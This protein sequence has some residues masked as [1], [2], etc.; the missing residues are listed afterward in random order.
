[1]RPLG[2]VALLWCA[3]CA[4]ACVE[5]LSA[6]GHDCLDFADCPDPCPGECVPLPPLGFDGPALLWMGPVSDL[7][8][9]CPERASRPVY[10]GFAGLNDSHECP[11]CECAE[12]ACVLPSGVTAS[13]LDACPN[14]GPGA[15]LT[16]YDAPSSWSG[17]CFSSGVIPPDK[18][19][20]VSIAPATVR[21]C[22]PVQAEVPA[23]FEGLSWATAAL[24]C[25]GEAIPNVCGD[26]GTTC[27]PSAKPPPPGF[28]QC[29]LHLL[30][31]EAQ[32]P[33]DY[34]EKY[35]LYQK[36]PEDTRACTACECVETQPSTCMASVSAYQ[37]TDCMGPVV[38]GGIATCVDVMPNLTLGSISA[39]WVTNEPGACAPSGGVPVG[40]ARP[41]GPST[42]CC[43]PPP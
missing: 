31:G 35:T 3:A 29:I 5:D 4:P 23:M 8:P 6:Y 1:M 16:P 43:Q 33:T 37:G 40:E 36:E 28:R 34:P 30:D 7:P 12:P 17:D 39:T 2:A 41:V 13:T 11:P 26:S 18:L 19:G 27:L 21:P 20:S 22:A 38:A 14:D 15:T 25:A 42:F 10:T 24:A 9:E 32:C